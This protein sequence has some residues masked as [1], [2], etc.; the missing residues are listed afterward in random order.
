MNEESNSTL[1]AWTDWHVNLIDPAQTIV[2]PG[3][4]RV[5]NDSLQ[6]AHL[7][8]EKI[9]AHLATHGDALAF[10]LE[11]DGFRYRLQRVR[12]H[13]YAART[14]RQVP[15]KAT[16]LGF[17]RSQVDLLLSEDLQRT[18][19]LVIVF[20]PTGSGKTTTIAGTIVSRLE[21]LG[22]YCLCVEDPPENILEGFHGEGYA[23]QMDA[24]SVGYE[25]ALIDAL[26]CF[27][28]GRPSMLMLGEIRSRA[29]AYEL[30]QIGLDGHLVLTTMHAKDIVSGLTRLVSLVNASGEQDVRPMLSAS[31]TLVLH[32]EMVNNKP[33]MTMLKF[34]QMASAIIK[35][36]ELHRLQDEILLQNK[37]LR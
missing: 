30:A 35:N 34:N 33:K 16:E 7:L 14:L 20:G 12:P 27:P 36:G 2:F 9:R 17:L 37:L 5:S 23:E 4:R 11:F 1:G 29:E 22:G 6:H 31:L 15:L 19:G 26:R 21:K 3:P 28:S 24:S 32:L 8:A 18:G 25:A 10:L 13:L